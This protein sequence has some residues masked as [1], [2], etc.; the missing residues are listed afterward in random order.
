MAFTAFGMV[1][2]Y[3]LVVFAHIY[4]ESVTTIMH[5]SYLVKKE[6]EYCL[7]ISSNWLTRYFFL[8]TNYKSGA[9]RM[10]FGPMF[11]VLRI[12]M[13]LVVG[14]TT[15]Q[16]TRINTM[17]AVQLVIFV[18]SAVVRPYRTTSSNALLF[19][20][21][22]L[23]V[24]IM[25]ELQLKV[26][27][28]NSDFLTDKYFFWLSVIQSTLFFVFIFVLM[29]VS[30]LTKATWPVTREFIEEYTQG[31]EMAIVQ[32]QRARKFKDKIL[33]QRRMHD[34]DYKELDD[35]IASLEHE[36]NELRDKQ[37]VIL[38]AMLEAMENLKTMQKNFN[39]LPGLYNF[40]Y[41]K[42]LDTTVIERQKVYEIAK[43]EDSDS[44]NDNEA[45]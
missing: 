10:Y 41:K 44:D 12:I 21:N 18:L 24:L 13:A 6:T 31:Q 1:I 11:N 9:Q 35:I 38:D 17:L 32:I 43:V 20:L 16:S 8:F 25:L 15:D 45:A 34:A 23:F 3:N 22:L 5:E 33:Q 14:L 19:L 39:E 2:I 36:F 29:L 30:C 42:S 37:P 28:F 40:D 7:G 27:G 26:G 4:T